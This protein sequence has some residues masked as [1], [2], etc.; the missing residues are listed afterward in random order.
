MTWLRIAETLGGRTVAEWKEV[1]G[2]QEF[3]EW[4]QWLDSVDRLNTP[5]REDHLFAM[6]AHLL[7]MLPVAFFGTK[8]P[9]SLLKPADFL[10]KFEEKKPDDTSEKAK[11][12]RARAEE[13]AI[14]A[15]VQKHAQ[16]A[17]KGTRIPRPSPKKKSD[18]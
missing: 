1:M 11:L 10:M 2:A 13:A 12:A 5:H 7:Y 15:A 6:I 8:N 3:H 17:K 16:G 14:I 4:E 9:G 18:K